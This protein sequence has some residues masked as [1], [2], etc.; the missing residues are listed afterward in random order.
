MAGSG[1]HCNAAK[2]PLWLSQWVGELPLVLSMKRRN[3]EAI[4]M[5]GAVSGLFDGGGY[6][7]SASMRSVVSQH[8]MK[9]ACNCSACGPVALKSEPVQTI[10]DFVSAPSSNLT[11]SAVTTTQNLNADEQSSGQKQS[12]NQERSESKAQTQSRLSEAEREQ[13]KELQKRDAEVRRHEQAHASAGGQ[14]AG[15]PTYTYQQG[16]DGRRYAIGGE[17]SINVAPVPDDPQATIQKME[18]VRRAALAPDEPSSQDQRVA[19]A[20]QRQAQEAQTALLQSKQEEVQEDLGLKEDDDKTEGEKKADEAKK[21][22]PASVLP[23]A[24]KKAEGTAEGEENTNTSTNTSTN[25]STPPALR[26]V[27]GKDSATSALDRN[28]DGK[29]SPIERDLEGK[30]LG[31]DVNKNL[32]GDLAGI[33]NGIGTTAQQKPNIQLAGDPQADGRGAQEPSNGL[34][35]RAAEARAENKV[36]AEVTKA[37]KA[38]NQRYDAGDVTPSLRLFA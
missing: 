12:G 21:S 30:K 28:G 25:G 23:G 31:D 32:T 18:Q 17:V 22:D 26:V 38:Y 10:S 8:S 20:A 7:A 6:I 13:V 35:D 14:Y 36:D 37:R 11:S 34:G 2:K 29:I 1:L 15:S 3:A 9:M 33:G 4:G 24:P 27:G 5:V 19:Q 16:P